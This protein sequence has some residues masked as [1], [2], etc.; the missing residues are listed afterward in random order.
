MVAA[1]GRQTT[2]ANAGVGVGA[3]VEVGGADAVAGVDESGV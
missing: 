2:V 1:G 3:D